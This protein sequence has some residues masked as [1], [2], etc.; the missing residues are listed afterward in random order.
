MIS[1]LN[2]YVLGGA[3]LALGITLA[4]GY[5]KGRSDGWRLSEAGH[6][7]AALKQAE[8][9]R[10]IEAE[11]DRL[12]RAAEAR[13][14][15][16]MGQVRIETRTIIQKVPVYVTPEIDRRYPLPCGFVRVHNAAAERKPVSEVTVPG[17]KSD[18]APAPLAVSDAARVIADNYGAYHEQSEQLK[19]LQESW[20]QAMI[21]FHPPTEQP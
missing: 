10:R 19:G 11:A 20:R 4:G 16:A 18:G 1:V 12:I 2:P 13:A 9:A 15:A 17:C 8:D 7:V 5:I 14:A 21:I 3:V 6:A